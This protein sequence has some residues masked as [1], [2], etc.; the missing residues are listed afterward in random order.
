VH[1]NLASI[2]ALFKQLPDRNL[3]DRVSKIRHEFSQWNQDKPSIRVSGMG[4][5]QVG[6]S[7]LLVA[8]KE[9]IDINGTWPAKLIPDTTGFAFNMKAAFQ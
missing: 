7:N 8:V 4:N 2:R 5:N 6:R 1:A 3:A 9:D